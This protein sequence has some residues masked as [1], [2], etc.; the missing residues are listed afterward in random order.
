MKKIKVYLATG[1][2]DKENRLTIVPDSITDYE[3]VMLKDH[4]DVV[5][6][7]KRGK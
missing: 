6:K 7:L 1:L 3:V 2:I 5:Q 4:L